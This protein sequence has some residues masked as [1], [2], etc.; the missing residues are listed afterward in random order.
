MTDTIEREAWIS[1]CQ[2]YR[3]SL[4]RTWDREKPGLTIVGL[5]PSTADAE[6]D[7]PT[8]RRCIRFARDHDFG[9]FT[10]INLFAYR[11]TSPKDLA[12]AGYPVGMHN[13]DAIDLALEDNFGCLVAWGALKKEARW[14]AEQTLYRLPNLVHCLG[15]TKS[16]DPRHPLYVRADAQWEIFQTNRTQP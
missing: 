2:Q 13:N 16:G 3:Y 12:D 9:S 8:I 7:D 11:A 15:R 5:N 14:Q 10:M 4:W 1:D 6:Q